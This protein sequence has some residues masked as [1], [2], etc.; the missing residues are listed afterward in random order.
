MLLSSIQ[1][2][3]NKFCIPRLG[4]ETQI[5]VCEI[6]FDAELIGAAILVMERINAD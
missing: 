2:T 6:G 3:F 5:Y 4:I 1:Q